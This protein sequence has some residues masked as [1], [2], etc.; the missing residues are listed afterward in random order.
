[1]Q[2]SKPYQGE[3]CKFYWIPGVKI[4]PV[5]NVVVLNQLIRV[6]RDK[7]DACSKRKP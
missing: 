4:V 1:M 6:Q 3:R 5:A 7:L 2:T